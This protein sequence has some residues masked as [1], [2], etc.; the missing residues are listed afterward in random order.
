ML[1]DSS[2]SVTRI[3]HGNTRPFPPRRPRVQAT[4]KPRTIS[5]SSSQKS[6]ACTPPT[7]LWRR[8][9]LTA[10]PVMWTNSVAEAVI[11]NFYTPTSYNLN[12]LL[13]EV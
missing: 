12:V 3:T 7:D 11:R 6:R 4:I 13:S 1:W 10:I 8:Y 2:C 9:Q 5:A